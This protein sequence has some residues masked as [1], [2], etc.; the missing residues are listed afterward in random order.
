MSNPKEIENLKG[1]K[2]LETKIERHAKVIKNL[3]MQRINKIKQLRARKN[4]KRTRRTKKRKKNETPFNI[5][6]EMFLTYFL[7]HICQLAKQAN[8]EKVSEKCVRMVEILKDA[9]IILKNR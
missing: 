5:P 6:K 7:R 9:I 1:I 3:E 2:N 4:K 8:K